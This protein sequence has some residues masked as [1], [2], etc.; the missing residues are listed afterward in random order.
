M[1]RRAPGR[2][3]A[4]GPKRP[5]PAR[6]RRGARRP[7]RAPAPQRR[8]LLPV[9]LVPVRLP[10][11]RQAGHAR[12]LPAAGR[13]RGRPGAGR[14]R[15]PQGR[16]RARPGHRTRL[17]GAAPTAERSPYRV[18]P[19]GPWS[20][21]GG[22]FGTPELLL[23]SGFRSPSGQLGRNLRIHPAC[24]VGARFAE[25]VRGWDGVMQSYARQRVGGPRAS[26]SR[27]PSRRSRSARSGCRAPG[28]STRSGCSPTTT[29][30]R[31]A[32]TSPTARR[33]GWGSPATARCGSPTG[34]PTTTR[35]RL[36][37]GIARAAELFYAAGATRG[38]SA[39]RRHPHDPEGPDRRP[40]GLAAGRR[41]AAP[42]GL[43]PDGHGAHGRR[44]RP[45]ASSRTDGAVHGA[46]GPLRRRRQP[47]AELDRRQPDDDHH[48]DGL[49]RR[50]PAGGSAELRG[51]DGRP[52]AAVA[53]NLSSPGRCA[54]GSCDYGRSPAGRR[55]RRRRWLDGGGGG[56]AGPASRRRRG[57]GRPRRANDVPSSCIASTLRRGTPIAAISP[58]QTPIFRVVVDAR[59]PTGSR[60]SPAG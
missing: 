7:P 54:P 51:S 30:P 31:P 33:A 5:A 12:L 59:C 53:V 40:R 9:Q 19:G 34:S 43:P 23:R 16:L 27:P 11:R 56:R 50:P 38:L 22:A 3:R 20:L 32:S 41:R 60:R 14:G 39:D 46:D 21:A 17:H 4:D 52:K 6:G 28:S 42:R 15:R 25:E 47:A 37:F 36:V 2:P 58:S 18:E 44:P 57:S 8:R 45:R 26:C 49:T 10:A 24:W 35:D 1:L 29:S 55:W 13:R 48:R